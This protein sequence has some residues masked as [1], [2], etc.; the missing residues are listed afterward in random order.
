MARLFTSGLFRA[1]LLV[2]ALLCAACSRGDD[3]QAIRALIAEGARLAEAHDVGGLAE[4][5]TAD[6]VAEPGGYDRDSLRGVLLQAF[7]YYGRFRVVFPPPSI[8]VD[9]GG[10]AAQG[11]IHFLIARREEPVPDLAGLV[12]DP[13]RWLARAG[14]TV[15]LYR[16]QVEFAKERRRWRARRAVLEPFN[17]MGWGE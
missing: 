10:D 11:E 4:L 6:F 2:T 15:D 17:G 1:T 5:A 12:D 16:L 13:R 8:E 9:A 14:K 7:L 3:A